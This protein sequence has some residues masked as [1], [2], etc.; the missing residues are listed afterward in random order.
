LGAAQLEDRLGLAADIAWAMPPKMPK[1]SPQGT[2]SATFTP[3]GT[4]SK[5]LRWWQ[6]SQGPQRCSSMKPRPSSIALIPVRQGTRSAG[7]SLTR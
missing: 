1:A 4:A 7:T 6:N 3:P 5:Q 2:R